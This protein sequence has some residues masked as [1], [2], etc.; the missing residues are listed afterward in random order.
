MPIH[1]RDEPAYVIYQTGSGSGKA[2][3]KGEEG[4]QR[5]AAYASGS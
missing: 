4:E 2:N 3:G 1:E 5:V